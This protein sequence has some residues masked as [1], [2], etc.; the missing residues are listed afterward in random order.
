MQ[1]S[2]SIKMNTINQSPQISGASHV[3]VMSFRAEC[4]TDVDNLMV[5]IPESAFSSFVVSKSS[6]MLNL[7]DVQVEIVTSSDM[8]ISTFYHFMSIVPDSHVMMQTLRAL[9]VC[10][11]S[12]IRRN[13]PEESDINW[14]N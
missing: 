2:E 4:M 12:M 5:M 1:P 9:A 7:P 3:G 14:L 11:N 10:D 8:T 13:F 6:E